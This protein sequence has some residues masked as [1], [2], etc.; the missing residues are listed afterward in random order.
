M[1]KY[2]LELRINETTNS[3]GIITE[4]TKTEISDTDIGGKLLMLTIN[5]CSPISLVGND[6]IIEDDKIIIYMKY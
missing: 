4:V 3:M 1:K 2:K 6:I 5:D